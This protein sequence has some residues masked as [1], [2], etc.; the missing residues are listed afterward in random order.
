MT[1]ST[2][3]FALLVELLDLVAG[4]G[5]D[6]RGFRESS[7]GD[8]GEGGI[9]MASIIAVLVLALVTV[10]LL[11]WLSPSST[12][13]KLKAVAPRALTVV[14]I[15]M[16][17]MVWAASSQGD[18]ERLTVE[19]ASALTGSPE[20]LVSLEDNDLNTLA[21]TDGKRTVRLRCVDR[22][23]R[24]VVDAEQRWP[25]LSERGY[26]YPHAHHVASLQT[27]VRADRC[28]LVGTRI[29]LEA[30]VEGAVTR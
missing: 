18:D 15:V 7:G 24:V 5:Y 4:H 26:E 22:E 23:G 13:A 2:V 12:R 14:L 9:G 30:G 28:R 1:P 29:P 11:V 16:P 25:L 17:L 27:V 8:D 19:R 20:L 10:G 3:S 21:T 6:F